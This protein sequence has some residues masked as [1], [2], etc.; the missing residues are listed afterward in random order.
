[1]R[2]LIFTI[3]LGLGAYSLARAEIR[4]AREEASANE[5]KVHQ[6]SQDLEKLRALGLGRARAYSWDE[7]AQKTLAAYREAAA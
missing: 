5:S 7:T 3:L 4:V 2:K 6:L 1:M